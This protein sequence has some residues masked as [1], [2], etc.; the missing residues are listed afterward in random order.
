MRRLNLVMTFL[1]IVTERVFQVHSNYAERSFRRIQ[2]NDMVTAWPAS[3]YTE[4][5]IIEFHNYYISYCGLL[6]YGGTQVTAII[7]QEHTAS[8]KME[9]LFT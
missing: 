6:S 5:R 8:L 7:P 1:I 3:G 4:K 9:E 2:N